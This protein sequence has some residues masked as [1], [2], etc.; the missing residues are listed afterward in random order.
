MQQK[1]HLIFKSHGGRKS[2][3]AM[4]EVEK[5]YVL[6]FNHISQHKESLY[7]E[8]DSAVLFCRNEYPEL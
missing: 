2:G 5:Q 8:I 6:K 3:H 1:W 4:L 7:S